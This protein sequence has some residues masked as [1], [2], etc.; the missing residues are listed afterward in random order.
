[1][2]FDYNW[3]GTLVTDSEKAFDSLKANFLITALEH[4]G[5]DFIKWSKV[6]VKN[7]ESY[8]INGCHTTKCL[9]LERGASQGDLISAYLFFLALEI[10]FTLIKWDK[11]I[12]GTSVFNNE[13]LNTTYADYTASFLNNETSVKNAL[14]DIRPI[15]NFS[16]LC[17]NL[18]K[19]KRIRVLKNVNMAPGGM[20]VKV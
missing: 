2:R 19:C 20:N 14:N 6:L 3:T 1:M 12:D 7:Q 18:D 8:R 13:Y 15:L 4:F 17:P 11:N 10:L 16:G 5:N 9:R